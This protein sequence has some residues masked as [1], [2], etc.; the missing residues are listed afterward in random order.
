MPE[1]NGSVDRK[2]TNV[3]GNGA[4]T[5]REAGSMGGRKVKELIEEGKKAQESLHRKK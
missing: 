5:V 1:K 4:M 3:P 2:K